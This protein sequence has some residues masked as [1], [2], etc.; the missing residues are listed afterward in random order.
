MG[1]LETES[2]LAALARRSGRMDLL[3]RNNSLPIKLLIW[4]SE[5][6]KLHR[7]KSMGKEKKKKRNAVSADIAN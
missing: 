3:G 1:S 7:T 4:E 2:N 5:E 6:K